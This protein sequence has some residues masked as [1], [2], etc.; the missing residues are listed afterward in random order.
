MCVP[1]RTPPFP[2]LPLFCIVLYWCRVGRLPPPPLSSKSQD[3]NDRIAKLEAFEQQ[4]GVQ[5]PNDGKGAAPSGGGGSRA[6]A[7]SLA[8]ALAPWSSSNSSSS[9][10]TRKGEPAAPRTER[11]PS[12][13]DARDGPP[14]GDEAG[15]VSAAE[16]TVIFFSGSGG[17][18]GSVCSSSGP[19]SVLKGVEGSAAQGTSGELVGVASGS[20]TSAGASIKSAAKRDT[21][22]R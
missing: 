2:T 17:G 5:H 6:L 7:L 14:L 21:H 22:R 9:S 10:S 16:G 19:G 4:R 15:H 12:T 1:C 13:R 3:I 11:V 20:S 18:G 8:A